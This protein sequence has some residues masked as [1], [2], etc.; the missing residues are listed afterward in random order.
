MRGIVSWGA[1]LPYRRLDRS[2][3]TAFL[4]QGGGRGTR[5]V[6]SYDEDA[7]TMGVEAS[8]LA[9]KATDA[10]PDSVM[11]ATVATPYVDKT[12]ATTVHA[13]LRLPDSVPAFDLG[14]SVR[15]VAGGLRF[16]LA[17]GGT[18]LLVTGDMRTGLAGSADEAAGGDAAA[19]LLV[20]EGDDVVAE[21]LGGASVTEEFLDRWRIPGDI[22]S[23][24]WD[25]KFSELTYVG[26]GRQALQ[27]G[28]RLRRAGPGR[29]R[30]ARRR[31][32]HRPHRQ[33][34]GRQAR[35]R[36]GGRPTSPTSVGAT[37]AAQPGVLLAGMLE[38]AE[39]GPGARP[40]GAG[41]RRRGLLLP[42]HPGARLVHGRP[43][44]WPASS[45]AAPRSPTTASSR[46]GA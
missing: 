3:I 42:H 2:Q 23:K 41:R 10:T 32:P 43:G 40:R 24:S 19:A 33:G 18:T 12:N 44:R 8:R 38:T 30:R 46:G 22:R 14:A 36:A 31:R 25:D 6:A 26:L 21:Y 11:F 4:G 35:R 16:A 5:T 34:H 27:G 28:P 29:H 15:S 37:G 1:Y 20:G 9:L 7:T 39:P 17:A 45:R 13:A